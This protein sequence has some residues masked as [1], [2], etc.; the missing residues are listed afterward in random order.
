MSERGSNKPESPRRS[1][2]KKGDKNSSKEHSSKAQTNK[3]DST[4]A[5][6]VRATLPTSSPSKQAPAPVV[7]ESTV[8]DKLESLTQLLSGFINNFT[9]SEP[10][11]SNSVHRPHD[12]SL[13]DGEITDSDTTGPDPLDR[14]DEVIS[15][16]QL[17]NSDHSELSSFIGL[18]V[19][20][21]VAVPQAPLHYKYLEIVRNMALI[22]SKGDYEAH[23]FL[24]VHSRD[25][26]RW[27]VDNITYQT[28]SIINP[29]PDLEIR[30][31]ASLTGWGAKLGSIVTGGNWNSDELNHINCLELKAVLL[32]LKSLC[33]EYRDTHVRLRSDNTTVIACIDRCASNKVSL[34]TIVEQIFEWTNMRGITLSAEYIKG[35]ENIEADRESRIKNNDIEWMLDRNIFS[36]LCKNYFVPELDLFATRINAQLCKFVAWKP[37]PDASYIDAFTIPWSCGFNYAFPPFSI[38][39]K[40]IQK[41]QEERATLL[42]ILPLW[43]TRV[44]FPR[45]LQLLV[46]DPVILPRNCLTLPQ[47]PYRKHPR[48]AMLRLTAMV[49][50]GDLSKVKAFRQKLQPF[51]LGHGEI[52]QNYNIG[53]ISR[54]GCHFVSKGKLIL[55][56]HL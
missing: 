18:V 54:N 28:K 7:S 19:F 55:F 52:Q 1:S 5:T 26:I 53:R 35:S 24:D 43:P 25:L 29:P 45:A 50:S 37:D 30:T 8:S 9:R 22:K 34:L 12:I 31:D 32:G 13:S 2:G 39:G 27:W 20:A 48:A 4:K 42:V 33:R 16:A 51:Y 14:L 23:T 36:A 44:W 3:E 46:E 40:M 56:N 10:E 38:I 41:M 21:G 17:N 15:P 47:D 6:H 49:L 11:T